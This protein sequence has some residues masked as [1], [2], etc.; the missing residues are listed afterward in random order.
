MVMMITFT[1]KIISVITI[2]SR[3]TTTIITHSA[4]CSPGKANTMLKPEALMRGANQPSLPYSK[5][6]ISP[7]SQ[8]PL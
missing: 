1:I 7:A 5:T 2:I 3:I 8:L 4:A 6:S